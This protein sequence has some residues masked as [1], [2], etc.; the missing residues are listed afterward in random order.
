[1]RML[2]LPTVFPVPAN[3]APP[4]ISTVLYSNF[5]TRA[6][7]QSSTAQKKAATKQRS[8]KRVKD[9]SPLNTTPNPSSPVPQKKILVPIGLGTEEMEAVIM[10]DVL[11]RAGAN[12]TVASVEEKLEVEAS[13]GTR[14]VA[15]ETISSCCDQTFDLIAL[16]GGMPGSTRLRDCQILQDITKKHAEAQRPYA[17]ICAAP[18]VTLLPWGLLRRKKVT[19]HPAFMDKLPT[20]WA[21]KSNLQVSGELTTS[22]GP[23]TCFQFSV[24]LAEQLFAGGNSLLTLLISSAQLLNLADDNSRKEEFDE[25]SWSLDHAP[26]VL[27]PVATGSEEIEVVTVVDILRRAKAKV[28]IA[29]VE[30]SLQVFATSGTKII[31]DTMISDAANMVYDLIIL[32]GGKLGS[33]KLHKSRILKKLLKEQQLGGRILG[34]MCSSP[35]ILHRQGNTDKR[36]TAHPSV[37]SMLN[38]TVNDARVVIDGKVV[39]C[40]G[41]STATDFALTITILIHKFVLVIETRSEDIE[42]SYCE[43][44]SRWSNVICRSLLNAQTEQLKEYG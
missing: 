39:T 30:K 17:A 2:S 1:M 7:T 24:S 6:A 10:I 5:S 9:S 34:A 35:T 4:F 42:T 25:V 37:I 21:V 11:R 19:C 8:L 26:Q 27:I 12:V 13:S 16:P 20:F 29:S 18:A 31:A 41:L 40:K 38:N 43:V 3:R 15:D 36:A 32:P 14:L 44:R 23:G 28:T 22:R 33:E